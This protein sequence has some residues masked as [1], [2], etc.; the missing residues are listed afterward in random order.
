[1]SNNGIKMD[2][3][4]KQLLHPKR[5]WS[6]KEVLEQPCPIPKAPGIYAWYF[7]DVPQEVPFEGCNQFSG[8]TLLYAG[9]SPKAP[10]KNGAKPSK[11]TLKDRLRYHFKG[12]AEGSTLRLTLGCLLSNKLD[13]QLRRVGSG[14]RF[15]FAQ[16][17]SVLSDWMDQNAFIAWCE[18]PTPWVPEEALIKEVLLPLNLD[19]N[20]HNSFYTSLKEIRYQAK[21]IARSLPIIS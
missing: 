15:T 19:Q 21:E 11:Q 2:D 10:P 13:I 20:H 14:K 18:H 4:Q 8:F 16:G 17:E 9:I 12:N 3:V 7:K 6:R 5:L 1:M